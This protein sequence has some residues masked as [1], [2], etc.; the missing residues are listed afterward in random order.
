MVKKNV[1]NVSGAEVIL[2]SAPSSK[3][4]SRNRCRRWCLTFNNWTEKD[5]KDIE[6]FVSMS[7][8]YIVVGAEIGKINKTKHLQCYLEGKNQI[9]F[10]KLKSTFPKAHLEKA[11]GKRDKNIEYCS[12]EG[13]VLMNT[14]PD[15]INQKLLKSY[16]EVIWKPWQQDVLNI[17]ESKPDSRTIY[18]FYDYQGNIGKSF[19]CKYIW[20]KYKCIIGSGKKQDIFHQIKTWMEENEGEEPEIVILDVPRTNIDYV[21]YGAIEEIKNGLIYSGKYEGG[22]CAF[23]HPH[24]IIFANSKPDEEK[25]SKDRWNIVEV[26]Q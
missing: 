20:L 19:L 23:N 26:S 9:D 12:K 13:N 8:C 22:V 17:I 24:V 6:A 5:L 7:Q 11:R 18:W 16:N 3:T 10:S 2:D 1:S 4:S 14:F 15:N 25:F 21:N